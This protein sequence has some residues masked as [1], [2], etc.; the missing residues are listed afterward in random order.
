ML[1]FSQRI[2]I[3]NGFRCES[4]K[5]LFCR[6]IATTCSI[7]LKAV[8]S[9]CSLDSFRAHQALWNLSMPSCSQS[10]HELISRTPLIKGVRV[11]RAF[12]ALRKGVR[13]NGLAQT[14][15]DFNRN[16]IVRNL[17]KNCLTPS[18][19]DPM[20][21]VPI[22]PNLRGRG[23]AFVQSCWRT[24]TPVKIALFQTS[25]SVGAFFGL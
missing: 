19:A 22:L 1:S 21:Q 2:W 14:S 24:S 15:M 23:V 9:S 18:S 13:R 5:G 6:S 10:Q 4:G 17:V 3:S 8:S 20:Y 25:R 11:V 16:R 7:R 12:S